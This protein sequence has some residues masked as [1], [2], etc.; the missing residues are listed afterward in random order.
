[1]LGQVSKNKFE[2]FAEGSANAKKRFWDLPR[3]RQ[4]LKN[5]LRLVEGSANAKKRF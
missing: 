3:V 4:T 5:N 1:M 2:P